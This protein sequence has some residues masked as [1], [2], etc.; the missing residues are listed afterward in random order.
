M[1]RLTQEITFCFG[2]RLLG[3]PGKCRHLHGHNGRAVVTLASERLDELGMVVDL[4]TVK[5]VLKS[6]I[7]RE[8]DHRMILHRDDPAVGVLRELGEPVV[9]V[10]FV[11][12]VENLAKHIYEFAVGEGLPVVEVELWETFTGRASYSAE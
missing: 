3:H 2:H 1:F 9:V 6:W 7:D 4:S 10:D 11:P 5:A 12:T 8:L